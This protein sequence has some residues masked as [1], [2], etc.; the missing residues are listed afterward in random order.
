MYLYIE[1]LI[2]LPAAMVAST[3]IDCQI[4]QKHNCK[5]IT[6][7][8]ENPVYNDKGQLMFSQGIDQ[9]QSNDTTPIVI[10]NDDDYSNWWAKKYCT[11]TAV[12]GFIRYFPY[13]L[14]VVAMVI[15]AIEKV[16][17]KTFKVISKHIIIKIC[18]LRI[19][20]YKRIF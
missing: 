10:N 12:D 13:T 17:T 16:F 8:M 18:L 11:E 19:S 9:T 14:F 1:G 4:C 3:P 7:Q 2:I 5:F 20:F 6:D 15:V